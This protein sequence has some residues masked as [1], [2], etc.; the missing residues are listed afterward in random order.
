MVHDSGNYDRDYS[1][2]RNYDPGGTHKDLDL[3]D[4]L[5]NVVRFGGAIIGIVLIVTGVT[6]VLKIFGVIVTTLNNPGNIR[7]LV[8]DWAQLI[9]NENLTIVFEGDEVALAP[10]I[11]IGILACGGL[12]L[13]S[14][15]IQ[16]I[17]NGAKVISIT[18]GEREAIK[19]L[20]RQLKMSGSIN[21]GN[22]R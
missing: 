22:T 2:P 7:T 13:A 14:I 10:V 15:S 4:L 1:I 20:F 11:A 5:Q 17:T 3:G 9:G 16:L 8:A 18:L 19:Q 21:V 6:F 12:V